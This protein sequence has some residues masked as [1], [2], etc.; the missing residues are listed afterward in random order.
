M[1]AAFTARGRAEEFNSLV[2]G[3][4]TSELLNTRYVEV[5]ELVEAMRYVSPVE[6]RAEFVAGLR[7]RLMSAAESALAPATDAE[8]AAR[9]TVAPR[10]TPRERRIAIAVGGF[11]IVGATTTMAMAAQTALP[12]DTLYPLKRALENAHAGVQVDEGDKGSTL[13]ANAAGRLDE[14]DE[15]SRAQGS[16][17]ATAIAQTLQAFTDQATAASD[18]LLASY[19]DN[20]QEASIQELRDFTAASMSDLEGLES[21]VPEEARGA[22]IAAAQV[23]YQ[24]D[25]QATYACPICAVSTVTRI[26]DILLLNVGN[27]FGT[28]AQP[29]TAP[30]VVDEPPADAQPKGNGQGKG[31][32]ATGT[33]PPPSGSGDGTP[34]PTVPSAPSGGGTTQD[35]DGSD[36]AD[37]SVI[38]ELTEGLTGAGKG[39]TGGAGDGASVPT[40]SPELD[41]VLEDTVDGVTGLLQP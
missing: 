18:L 6:A 26:P 14:V 10:R 3:T 24:I 16:E 40:Q 1:T 8:L 13:L 25:Q 41:E 20:G 2:E 31:A 30:S 29:A 33:Q 27:V 36:D 4:S 32:P 7:S 37:A 12:G 11:A 9:L 38:G 15:L 35:P 17:D 34:P 19:A 23:L 39:D 21:V 5:L 28:T 22:L